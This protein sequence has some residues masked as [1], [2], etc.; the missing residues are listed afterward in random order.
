MEDQTIDTYN[1]ITAEYFKARVSSKGFSH[2]LEEF[3]GLLQPSAHILDAGCGFGRD[4]KVFTENGFQVTGIDLSENMI[5]AA[6]KYAPKAL[7]EIADLNALS[8]KPNSF[9]AIWAMSSLVHLDFDQVAKVIQD[10]YTLLK[11]NGIL[12]ICVKNGQGKKVVRTAEFRNLPLTFYYYSKEQIL[13]L[14]DKNNFQLIKYTN[15]QSTTGDWH[16]FYFRKD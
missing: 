3:M 13:A 9:N 6:R 5:T 8:F 16:V 7:F 14:A 12:F 11:K 1:K 4:S 15:A 2:L 10:F